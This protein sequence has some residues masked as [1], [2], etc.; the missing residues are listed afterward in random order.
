MISILIPTKD[1]VRLIAIAVLV[2]TIAYTLYMSPV[3]QTDS[4]RLVLGRGWIREARPRRY[5]Y[6]PNCV[7][8]SDTEGVMRD[9]GADL[10]GYVFSPH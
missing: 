8:G 7:V 9:D 4:N 10:A 2:R 1:C 5:S 3:S 6:L